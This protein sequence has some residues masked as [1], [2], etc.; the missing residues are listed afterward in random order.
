[1]RIVAKYEALQLDFQGSF[2]MA[3]IGLWYPVYNRHLSWVGV[4]LE[5]DAEEAASPGF[6][7]KIT[8]DFQAI[9]ALGN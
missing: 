2:G 1:M 7:S 9:G 5:T 4:R 6:F 3:M 8:D